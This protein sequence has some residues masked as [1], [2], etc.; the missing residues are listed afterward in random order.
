MEVKALIFIYQHAA[1]ATPDHVDNSLIDEGLVLTCRQCIDENSAKEFVEETINC[2][3]HTQRPV[4]FE[5]VSEVREQLTHILDASLKERLEYRLRYVEVLYKIERGIAHISSREQLDQYKLQ[6]HFAP[7]HIYKERL[8]KLLAEQQE[9]VQPLTVEE[10]HLKELNFLAKELFDDNFVNIGK[11][12]REQLLTEILKSNR[13][14]GLTDVERAIR[15]YDEQL[16][17]IYQVTDLEKRMNLLS[18]SLLLKFLNQTIIERELRLLATELSGNSL[19]IWILEAKQLLQKDRKEQLAKSVV[20]KEDG[21][22][23]HLIIHEDMMKE[24]P[25]IRKDGI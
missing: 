15:K 14:A 5:G 16:R 20:Y 12:A 22:P 11:F 17:D 9:K 4:S 6:I 2:F 21:L 3:E 8:K 19:L 10:E 7:Q 25:I 18:D 23:A 13:N 24:L 1:L